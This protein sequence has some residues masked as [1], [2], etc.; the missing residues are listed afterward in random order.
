MARATWSVALREEQVLVDTH[1]HLIDQSRLGYPW[2]AGEPALNRDF[3]YAEY[4]RD[5]LRAGI[6]DV[7]HMEVDVAPAEVAS[8]IEFVREHSQKPGNLLRGAISA[9]RPSR[10]A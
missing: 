10:L 5:A 1:L 3:P 8:E 2:L 7:L 9:C 4:A 6:T